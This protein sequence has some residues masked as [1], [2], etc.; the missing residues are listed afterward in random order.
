MESQGTPRHILN[1]SNSKYTGQI[2]K[3]IILEETVKIQEIKVHLGSL[4]SHLKMHFEQKSILIRELLEFK[5]VFLNSK[6]SMEELVDKSK[7]IT[8]K[9][10]TKDKEKKTQEGKKHKGHKGNDPRDS[11]FK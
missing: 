1:I 2:N 11:L 5:T 6:K 9:G 7:K 8:Q 10:E 3:E 4:Q